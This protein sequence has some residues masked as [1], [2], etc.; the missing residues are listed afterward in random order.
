M[1][2]QSATITILAQA[3]AG[4]LVTIHRAGKEAVPLHAGHDA[5]HHLKPGDRITIDVQSDETWVQRQ[6]DLEER[7]NASQGKTQGT[8]GRTATDAASDGALP[9]G[10]TSGRSPSEGATATASGLTKPVVPDDD[11]QG[12]PTSGGITGEVVRETAATRTTRQTPRNG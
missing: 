1:K 3:L 8:A 12:G 10:A 9:V 5:L 2:P 6:R 7:S 4:T 11:G